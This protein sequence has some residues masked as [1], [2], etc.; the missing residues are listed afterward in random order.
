MDRREFLKGTGWMSLAAAAAGSQMS[1]VCFGGDA[2]MAEFAVPPIKRVRIGFVGV[3]S[4]G[5]VAYGEFYLGDVDASVER[6]IAVGDYR[7][8]AG[9][10]L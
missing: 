8:Q 10:D 2:P 3:L 9:W 7:I 6:G 1:K 4:D 5:S